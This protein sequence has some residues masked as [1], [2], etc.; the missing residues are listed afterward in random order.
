MRESPNRR[1]VIVGL[2]VFIG[3]IFLV[4]GVLMV[5]NL[6]ETFKKKMTVTSFFDD[7]NGL[8]AG[9]NIWFSGVKVGTVKAIQFHSRSAVEVT[10]RIDV[11]TQEYIRQDAKVKI[12]TDGL[13]GNKILVI[14]GGSGKVGQIQEGDTLEVEKSVSQ[15]DMLKILQ[16]SNKNLNSITTDFKSISK[17]L[18][19]GEGTMG[20][21]INDNSLYDNANKTIVSLQQTSAK[22]QQLLNNLNTYTAKLNQEGT[23]ANELVSDT[24]VFNSIREFAQR[25]KQIADT[26]VVLVAQ[27][28][29]IS[30]DTSTSIGVLLHDKEEGARL[31]NTLKNLES[32]S[33]KLDEDLEAAQHSWPLKKGFRKLEKA[34]SDS[35]ENNPN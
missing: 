27:L 26:T 1:A 21:L 4:S 16:E 33:K 23:L 15:E 31:K 13:I 2:F 20:K 12:S 19:S 28:K 9:N 22:G 35:I 7:V 34:K 18:D 14:Y 30:K 3:L 32:S 25:L 6:H 11:K 29:T 8:Q 24:V 10:M 17:K 5:G